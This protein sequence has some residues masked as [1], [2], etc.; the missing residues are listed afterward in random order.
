M[1]LLDLSGQLRYLF[2]RLSWFC[3]FGVFVLIS[4]VFFFQCGTLLRFLDL[5]G[6]GT[7]LVCFFDLFRPCGPCGVFF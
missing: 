6:R 1:D 2:P 7:V 4:L 5:L 3:L